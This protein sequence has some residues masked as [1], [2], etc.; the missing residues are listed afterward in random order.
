MRNLG[1]GRLLLLIAACV[2][3]F[4]FNLI[5]FWPGIVSNDSVTTYDMGVTGRYDDWSPLLM[6]L[7]WGAVPTSPPGWGMLAIDSALLAG[8]LLFWA[9]SLLRRTGW[10]SVLVLAAYF[11]PAVTIYGGLIWR[12][13]LLAGFFLCSTGALALHESR[14]R[15]GLMVTAADHALVGLAV[16]AGVLGG[17]TRTNG[18]FAFLPIAFYC[19]TLLQRRWLGVAVAFCILFALPPVMNKALFKL[20]DSKPTY[21]ENSLLVFDLGALSKGGENFFPGNWTDTEAAAIRDTCYIYRAWDTY[22]W[23]DCQFVSD[24][25]IRNGYWN[26]S[27]KYVWFRAIMTHPFKYAQHRLA[28]YFTLVAPPWQP[29]N[30][31]T[32]NSLGFD[33]KP[34]LVAKGLSWLSS[35]GQYSPLNILLLSPFAWFFYGRLTVWAHCKW[36]GAMPKA[37][38]VALLSALFYALAY[39]A[40]GVANDYRYVYWPIVAVATCICV[41][42]A[43]LWSRRHSRHNSTISNRI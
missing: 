5:S 36:I 18:F 30:E 31:A 16:I 42:A 2:L 27:L 32:P 29:F 23:G 37:M 7:I 38:N 13:V 3:V 26:N 28:Y 22:K 10:F 34:G 17:M 9:M 33:Y 40:V 39:G 35:Q 14:R 1:G 6:S 41:V 4:A 19:A 11:F 15:D 8:G 43:E 25:L 20:T 21:V 12:D 24:H